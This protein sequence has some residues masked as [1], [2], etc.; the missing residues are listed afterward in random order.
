MPDVKAPF[1]SAARLSFV[2]CN[3]LLPWFSSMP[4]EHL[5]LVGI[6]LQLWNWEHIGISNAVQ[7]LPSQ[8][9]IMAHAETS[10]KNICPQWLS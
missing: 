9:H 7:H 2:D 1:R 4:C 3:I 6:P 10:L 8:L 5:F